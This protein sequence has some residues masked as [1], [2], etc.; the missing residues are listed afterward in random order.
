M[1]R[2]RDDNLDE[3]EYEICGLEKQLNVHIDIT[4]QQHAFYHIHFIYIQQVF[5]S[6]FI[7]EDINLMLEPTKIPLI[8]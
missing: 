2:L 3:M 1:Q 8:V 7:L 5:F 6:M 4:S